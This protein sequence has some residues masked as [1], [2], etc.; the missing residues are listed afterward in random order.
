MNNWH[1]VLRVMLIIGCIFQNAVAE[2]N[3]VSES[4][5]ESDYIPRVVVAARRD[6]VRRSFSE[7]SVDGQAIPVHPQCVDQRVSRNDRHRFRGYQ[8]KVSCCYYRRDCPVARD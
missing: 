6:S 8:K 4:E 3:S 5:Y 2:E 1:N 7:V